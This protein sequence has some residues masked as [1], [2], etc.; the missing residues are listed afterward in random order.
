MR[1]EFKALEEL[2]WFVFVAVATVVLQ[3]LVEFD[4]SRV[5]DWRA[6]AVGVGAA[7]VRSGAGAALAWLG[8][9]AIVDEGGD[10]GGVAGA[11]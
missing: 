6:W 7:A 1:Y 5:D 3:A 9:R 11:D 10:A 8:K 4:P 2:G